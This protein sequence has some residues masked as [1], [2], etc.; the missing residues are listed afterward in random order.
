VSEFIT[1]LYKLAEHC[2]FQGLKHEL[3]RDRIV[4]GIKNRRLSERL[5]LD[6]KLT[7]ETATRQVKQTELVKSQQGVVHGANEPIKVDRV[8][9]TN[10]THKRKQ[11]VTHAPQSHST[12]HK[13]CSRCLY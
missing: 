11:N 6:A 9:K 10:V 8:V 1:D 2:D 13:T 4:V 3:I 12:A 5:Q 7:L